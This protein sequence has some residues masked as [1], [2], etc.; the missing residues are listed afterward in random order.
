M[1]ENQDL[2]DADWGNPYLI[3]GILQNLGCPSAQPLGMKVA[4]DP[5]MS[6]QK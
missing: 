4:P 2:P 3:S 5:D 1:A 6:I